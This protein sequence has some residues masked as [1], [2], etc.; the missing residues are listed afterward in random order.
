MFS[1]SSSEP[2]SMTGKVV[3]V[4]G[5]S[6]GLGA[7]FAQVVAAMGASV[8]LGARRTER[9]EEV[10]QRIRDLGGRA[11]AVE[12]DVTSADAV[13]SALDVV[14]SEFGAITVLVN[15]AGVADSR[16]CLK[17]DEESWDF[18][19]DTNL[20]GA[21]RVARAVAERCVE[22]QLAASIVNVASVLGDCPARC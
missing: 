2:F 14:E 5:A 7:H 13:R 8:A 22:N 6:S 16:Y 15:N 20:K 1:P 21:W 9:L 3:L 4:T 17:V 11:M 18:V 10:V 19:M 12:L